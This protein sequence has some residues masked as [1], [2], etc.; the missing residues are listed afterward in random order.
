MEVFMN[1]L[2]NKFFKYVTFSTMTSIINVVVYIISFRCITKNVIISNVIA[3]TISISLS[4]VINKNCVF[5]N[6]NQNVTKQLFL[7]LVVKIISFIVDSCVLVIS[8]EYL[9]LNN[10]IS[11][12]IAN[13]STTISNYTLNNNM[14]FKDNNC[15]IEAKT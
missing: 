6:K 2:N 11:K 9:G 8:V 3:Y 4:F 13:A 5:E 15:I 1:M 10:L 14:V 12:L 7:Y